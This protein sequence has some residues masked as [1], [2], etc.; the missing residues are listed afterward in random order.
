MIVI[1][2]SDEFQVGAA[3]AFGLMG[4]ADAIRRWDEATC[5]TAGCLKPRGHWSAC[6]PTPNHHAE[7]RAMRELE[8]CGCPGECD[9][10]EPKAALP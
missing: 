3:V 5:R 10:C 7:V 9:V 6:R 2:E 4:M 1:D 8:W